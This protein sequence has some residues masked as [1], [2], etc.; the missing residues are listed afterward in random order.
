MKIVKKAI[1]VRIYLTKVDQNDN[2]EKTASIDK[3]ESGFGI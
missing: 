1:K 2:G 3:I